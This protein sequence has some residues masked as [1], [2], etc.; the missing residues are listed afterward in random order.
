[1]HGAFLL[2]INPILSNLMLI[3]L[4]H[5]SWR[6]PN[7]FVWQQKNARGTRATEPSATRPSVGQEK[8]LKSCPL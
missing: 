1:M 5:S 3:L 6:A 8:S 7:N 2:R 4:I